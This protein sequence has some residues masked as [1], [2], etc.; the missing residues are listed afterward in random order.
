M[1]LASTFFDMV[2]GVDIHIEMVPTPAG[3]VP[4]PFPN[5]FV[6]MVMDPMTAAFSILGP[7]LINGVLANNTGTEA[8]NKLGVPHILIPPGTAWMPMP[9]PPAPTAGKGVPEPG[10]PAA[11]DGDA[12][13]IMGSTSVHVMGSNQVRLAE[14]AMSCGEPVRL[15]SSAVIAVPKGAPVLVGGAPSLDLQSAAFA[16]IRTKSIAG[17]L[18]KLISKVC[19]NKRLASAFHKIACALTGHPVDVAS[20]RVLTDAIDWELPGP[21]PVVFERNYISAFAS[22]DSAVGHGWSH[23]LDQA[24]W[25]ERGCVVYLTE[26]G[27]EIEFDTFD[28]P[29]HVMRPGDE[30]FDRFTTLTLRCL[31][32]W[33]WEVQTPEG[34][35]H[36]F[37]PVDRSRPHRSRLIRSRTRDDHAIELSYDD[38]GCLELLRDSGGRLVRMVHDARGHLTEVHLPH[39]QQSGTWV[40]HN[41]YRYDDAGD[42][43][44]VTDPQGH[45]IRMA[46]IGHLLVEETDR[47]GLTFR[48]G[49]DDIG[50]G[51]KCIRTWG[52]GGIHDHV[53]DYDVE[54]RITYVT[55]SCDETTIYHMNEAGAVIR[56]VDPFGAAKEWDYDDDLNVVAERDANGNETVYGFDGRGNCTSVVLPDGGQVKARYDRHDNVVWAE[57]PAGGSWTWRYDRFGRPVEHVDAGGRRRQLEW[58][59]GHLVSA[60]DADGSRVQ[61]EYD[62]AHNVVGEILAAGQRLEGRWD[63]RGRLCTTKLPDGERVTIG[64]DGRDMA[65]RITEPGGHQ[66]RMDYNGEGLLVQIE[67]GGRQRTIDYTGYHRVAQVEQ[68]GQRVRLIYD[69]EDRL[70]A[71]ENE[72]GKTHRFELDARGIPAAEVGFDDSRVEFEHD[73]AGSVTLV[74]RPDGA[75]ERIAHDAGGR[76]TRVERSD[77]TF[78]AFRYREDGALTEAANEAVTITF[79]HDAMGRL[80]LEQRGETWVRSRY[81]PT[82]QRQV[83]ESSEG[84]RRV[85]EYAPSGE[86]TKVEVDGTTSP[87]VLT[88][89]RDALGQATKIEGPGGLELRC[90]YDPAGRSTGHDVKTGG[91]VIGGRRQTWDANGTLATRKELG[92][93]EIKYRYDA[94]GRPIAAEHAGGRVQHRVF[95]EVGNP[96]RHPQFNDRRHAA[97]GVVQWVDG[98]TYEFDACGQL[99]QK[100]D[101]D[102]ATWRYHWTDGGRLRMVTR[103]DGEQVEMAYDA[104]GRRVQLD[105]R[106]AQGQARESTRWIWD[107]SVP[108]HQQSEGQDTITWHFEEQTFRPIAQQRAGVWHTIITDAAVASPLQMVAE[109]GAQ[110]WR[111]SLDLFGETSIELDTEPT[112]LR[113]AGQHADE[114]TGL[115]YNRHR[116]YDPR[117]GQYISKDPIGL[118]GQLHQYGYVADPLQWIDPLGQDGHH[119]VPKALLKEMLD[120]GWIDED[121][122]KKL[123][124]AGKRPGLWQLPRDGHHQAHGALNDYLNAKHGAGLSNWG[125]KK[126]WQ[127]YLKKSGGMAKL[128]G[129]FDD[130]Y[131]K[132]LPAR[133]KK[134]P[135]LKGKTPKGLAAFLADMAKIKK[136]KTPSCPK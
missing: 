15:P 54:K 29:D 75:E 21:L 99:E 84:L 18:H 104:F 8:V 58:D 30:I 80:V 115:Y 9:K 32:N 31:G 117:L 125:G 133:T 27:R 69:T 110:T 79:E 108:V 106:S 103:P 128:L 91:Q 62:G 107:Q 109:D 35:V 130:F 92:Q 122:Y 38:R 6:G 63:R 4:T 95:D 16:A 77:G 112:P 121:T 53:I 7:V 135:L 28:F 124:P 86:T 78:E 98:T 56:K 101:A 46:Y 48:F 61:L 49:Y 23:P 2:V 26:D 81:S 25:V 74:R 113:W 90:W 57:D 51:A 17:A 20:G 119:T 111:G 114:K 76:V 102:G 67:E 1:T 59:Q 13:M 39:P 12:V 105:V 89:A 70:L 88:Y 10:N 36:E 97:S 73:P 24:V 14:L 47:T 72:V 87:R 68:A 85:V 33:R 123:K 3:P 82:G 71:V 64:W 43:V 132:W 55:N 11:P 131:R 42:L 66:S 126:G 118:C 96:H 60:L 129:D 120:D 5:P 65:S 94:Q 40:L 136:G 34:V 83:V 127:K 41:R 134:Y 116:Y 19:K 50:D 52:D 44:E 100:V 93:G 45:A 22:R 37:A